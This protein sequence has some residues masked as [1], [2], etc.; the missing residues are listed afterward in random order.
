MVESGVSYR[1]TFR[2]AL[3]YIPG[4][5]T[6]VQWLIRI[7]GYYGALFHWIERVG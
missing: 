3:V 2:L 6:G 7:I 4:G 1:L 5:G